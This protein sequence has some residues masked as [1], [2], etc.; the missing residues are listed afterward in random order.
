MVESLDAVVAVS[1]GI[2]RPDGVPGTQISLTVGEVSMFACKDSFTRFLT[3]LG[4]LSSELTCLDRKALEELRAKSGTLPENSNEQEAD[5]GEAVHAKFHAFEDLKRQSALR[6][7][8]GT[9]SETTAKRKDFLLDGYDWTTID[10]DETAKSGV[11]L[12]EEQ[13]ARWYNSSETDTKASCTQVDEIAF[14]PSFGLPET[15]GEAKPHEGPR[16]ISHHF[17]LQPESDPLG[18]GDMGIAK[19]AGTET[20]LMIR[21][22]VLVHD[23]SIKIRCFDGFDW[24][25]LLGKQQRH[26]AMKGAF[27][28]D[29]GFE[30]EEVE[31]DEP[32]KK[33]TKKDELMGDLLAGDKESS[34]TFQGLP[35]PEER[36][37]QLMEQGELRK[38][39]RRAGKYFQVSISGVSLRVDS[40]EESDGHNLVSS[41]NVKARDFFLAETISRDFPV[42]L[43]GEWLSD[44]SHPRD[45][46]EGLFMMKVSF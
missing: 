4:E 31:S 32:M 26:D 14:L 22:R 5:E 27:L 43:A 24:P 29:Q 8:A 35:I 6:P 10:Q 7:T 40:L 17:P 25:E 2:S 15:T 11:P 12:G 28:L 23:L 42:K 3:C 46:K 1:N 18:D 21:T 39:S 41:L 19:Y 34:N 37:A 36:G 20:G 44:A 16:I 13:A 33:P 30:R 9:A 45:T 38:L